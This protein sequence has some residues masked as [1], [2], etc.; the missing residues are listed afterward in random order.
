M[1]TKANVLLVGSGGVGTMGAYALE[2]GGLAAV[3]A[4]LRSNYETVMEKGFSIDSIEHG[5]GIKGFKPSQILKKVPNV[6][7]DPS[8]KYHFI[9]VTTKNI[10]DVKPTVEE[11]IEPAVTPGH[12]AIVLMQNGL[13]IEKPVIAKFPNNVVLSGVS[14]IGATENPKGHIAHDDSDSLKIGPYES[15]G[16][17]RETAVAAAKHFVK[18]YNACGKVDCTFDEDVPF[19][20][21]RKLIY[22]A[23]Y[24]SVCTILRW[25]TLRMRMYEH[26]IDSLIRP[27]ML[28]IKATAR[29]AGV[30]L[31]EDICEVLIAVDPDGV[32]WK[33]SMCQDIEK[34]NFI[35]YE[36][37]V[38]EPVRE[39]QKLGVPTPVL[40]TIYG[41]LKSLQTMT[42]ESKGM[43]SPAWKEN[44]RYK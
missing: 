2:T 44:A 26:A 24:N 25:D 8:L 9:V 28:E 10:A 33:P 43:I 34:G 20:R 11:I 38:G 18:I 31:P 27:A 40:S 19:T 36:N 12:T 6:S 29:A 16:V 41:M 30:V 3:S 23:S 1:A 5:M 4:V 37:I 7:T 21:W 39:A 35:E 15:P 14:F 22:N 13:N 42:M 17:K 32:Y